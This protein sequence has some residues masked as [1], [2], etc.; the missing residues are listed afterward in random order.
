M[1]LVMKR[2]VFSVMTMCVFCANIFAQNTPSSEDLP[3]ITDFGAG[4]LQSDGSIA[5]VYPATM[6]LE[7]QWC[8]ISLWRTPFSITEYPSF[9]VRLQRGFSD[10]G[11]V[12]LFMRNAYSAS[13]YGGP[14]VKFEANQ[15]EIKGD[16]AEF[17]TEGN[18]A[19]DPVCTWFA[20]QYTQN[21]KVTVAVKE[22]VLIDEDGNEVV[23]HNIRNDSWKPSPDWKDPDSVYEADV[24]F[25]SKGTVGLYRGTVEEGKSHVFKF[26]TKEPIPEGFTLVCVLDDG[27]YTTTVYPVPSGSTEYT[28]PAITENYLRVYLEYAGTYPQTV[29]FSKISREI[30]ESAGISGTLYDAGIAKREYF[31]VSGMKLKR[32]GHGMYIMRDIMNDGTVKTRKRIN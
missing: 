14:Y 9:R 6:T 27:D 18:F 13:N 32:P 20:I 7:G 25:T 8:D 19:D 23:S 26:Q 21:D 12:Q 16:F 15:V 2:I 29:H 4:V 22:A 5:T 28:S 17:D 24:K 10:D 11:V 30:H 3:I 1:T 31:S